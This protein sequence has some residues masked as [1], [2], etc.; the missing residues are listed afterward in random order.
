MYKWK[1]KAKVISLLYFLEKDF[2]KPAYY[3][4]KL[5]NPEFVIGGGETTRDVVIEGDDDMEGMCRYL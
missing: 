2:T 1:K 3:K 5:Y 4:R